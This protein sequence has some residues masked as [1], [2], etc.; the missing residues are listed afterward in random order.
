MYLVLSLRKG[1]SYSNFTSPALFCSWQQLSEN[2]DYITRTNYPSINYYD[3][4]PS[5]HHTSKDPQPR[6]MTTS[7]KQVIDEEDM[8]KQ[9]ITDN[10]QS[11]MAEE[12]A[13]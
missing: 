11:P 4:C 2:I 10:V 8:G 12:P 7:Q 9:H 5:N 13:T 1:R 6:R 3:G